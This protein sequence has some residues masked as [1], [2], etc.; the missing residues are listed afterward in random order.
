MERTEPPVT[1]ITG[2]RKGIG[3]FLAEHY[4]AAGHIVFGCSREAPDWQREGYHHIRADVTEEAAVR[5]MFRQ[6]RS[7]AGRL[8]H[9]VNNAGI[10]AMNHFMLTPLPTVDRIFKTNVLG[11]YLLCR[12]AARLM[13]TR[14]YGRIVNFTTVANPLNLE[15]EAAYAAS[16]A[17]VESLTRIASR[18]L[19]PLG[20]TLNAVGPTPIATDLIRAVPEAKIQ[21]LLARQALPRMGTFDDVAHVVDFFLAPQSHFITGQCLYLGGVN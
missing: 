14:R 19:A 6:V 21:A 17:A 11:T 13:Q 2:T 16:K 3:K 15:G 9:L 10:A 8:D 20:I 5:A 12:E 7:E 18:E 1:L 4:V